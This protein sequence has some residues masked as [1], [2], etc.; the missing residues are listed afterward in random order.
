MNTAMK[1]PYFLMT[2][3]NMLEYT[4]NIKLSLKLQRQ[5]EQ[6]VK[7]CTKSYINSFT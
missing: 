4:I 1:V 7:C 2:F 3:E 5:G 6:K